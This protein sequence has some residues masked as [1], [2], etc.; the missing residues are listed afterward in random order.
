MLGDRAAMLQDG[1]E[2]KTPV[3]DAH[4]CLQQLIGCAVYFEHEF[5]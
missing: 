1:Q 5:A 3:R 2:E 4:M